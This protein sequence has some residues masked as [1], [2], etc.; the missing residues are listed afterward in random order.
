MIEINLEHDTIRVWNLARSES[1][2]G[3]F[4]SVFSLL[5]KKVTINENVSFKCYAPKIQP[6]DCDKL[7]INWKIDNDVTICWHDVFIKFFWSCFVSLVKCSYSSK[8]PVNFITGSGVKTIIFYKGL[9]RDLE[10]GNATP[11]FCPISRD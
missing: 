5:R 6:P 7:V 11:E 4:R 8:F 1:V 9:I 3:F 10:I 2:S